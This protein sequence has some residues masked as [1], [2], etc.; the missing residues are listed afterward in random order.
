MDGDIAPVTE[1]FTLA[2]RYGAGVIVDEAHAT[3]VH[4]PSGRG[5]A[6][7]SGCADFLV[8]A[9]HPCGKALASVGAFVCGS[10]VLKEH[11]I[12]HARTFVFSTAQPPYMAGQIRAALRLALVM[13][14]EREEL[15]AR[16]KRFAATLRSRGWD[17]GN[18]ATQIV[19]AMIGGNE[20]AIAAAD[21]LQDEG[22]A[23][24]PIRPPTVPRGSARLRFSLTTGISEDALVRLE[25]SL[26]HWREIAYRSAVAGRA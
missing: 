22:F 19:P 4:G 7:A 23:V 3:A 5:I 2:D 11:L 17:T 14:R 21:F 25:N 15:H 16:S 9:V 6:A 18:S 26:N 1:I 13:D 20:E 8:A 12:N 24:R 10:A